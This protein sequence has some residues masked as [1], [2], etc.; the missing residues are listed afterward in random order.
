MQAACGGVRLALHVRYARWCAALPRTLHFAVDVFSRRASLLQVMLLVG[1]LEDTS[2]VRWLVMPA[3]SRYLSAPA[4]A[5]R[6]SM[7]TRKDLQSD[8]QEFA[9]GSHP[10]GLESIPSKDA[11][12]PP[13]PTTSRNSSLA[14]SIEMHIAHWA[15]TTKRGV[16]VFTPQRW[17]SHR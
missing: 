11:T 14:S 2:F 8:F 1:L 15:E 3:V 16:E 5:Q 12:A 17:R 4:G 13:L 10:S 7:T 6:Q 9:C